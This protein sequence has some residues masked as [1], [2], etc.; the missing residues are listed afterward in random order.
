VKE[1]VLTRRGYR[2]WERWRS[3]RVCHQA[4]EWHHAG[5]W[6]HAGEWRHAEHCHRCARL[7]LELATVRA[8]LATAQA[9]EERVVVVCRDGESPDAVPGSRIAALVLGLFASLRDHQ[10]VWGFIAL[11]V[12]SVLVVTVYGTVR[13]LT[14]G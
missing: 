4:G 8:E 5:E 10:W 14:G 13:F 7:E 9:A 2:A 1:L 12:G 6:Q 11:V 3:R